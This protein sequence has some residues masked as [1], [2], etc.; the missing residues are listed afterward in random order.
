MRKEDFDKSV[1]NKLL[2][3]K[4]SAISADEVQNI[5]NVI[6]QIPT[7]VRWYQTMSF[8]VFSLGFMAVIMVGGYFLLQKSGHFTKMTIE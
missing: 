7:T 2:S 3:I 6:N 1:K 8:K 4:E 5:L